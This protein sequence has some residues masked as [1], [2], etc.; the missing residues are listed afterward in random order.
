MKSKKAFTLIELLVVIA[1]IA[2]L[3][4]IVV[5]ALRKAKMAAVQIV[6][7]SHLRQTGVALSNFATDFEQYPNP[8]YHPDTRI[9][10]PIGGMGY[11]VPA[12]EAR[13]DPAWGRGFS[14]GATVVYPA[15]QFVL[16][17][18]G[19][20]DDPKFLYCPATVGRSESQEQLNYEDDY[21]ERIKRFGDNGEYDKIMVGYPYWVGYTWKNLSPLEAD[22]LTQGT[23]QTL[24]DHGSKVAISDAIVT[25]TPETPDDYTDSHRNPFKSNHVTAGIVSG[26]N[27]LYK[28]THVKW[29]PMQRMQNDWQT[30]RRMTTRAILDIDWWF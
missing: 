27:V 9:R 29:S 19:Y 25:R 10:W 4:S 14:L 24:T 15:G 7:S 18:M 30:R 17:D 28:D 16:L 8:N 1:I 20:L 22:K 6:C 11:E 2:L 3:I 5:P 12:S 23:V 13:S 26:G 21:I